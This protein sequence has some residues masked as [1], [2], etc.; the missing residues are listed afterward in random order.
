VFADKQG[1]P[2][3]LSEALRFIRKEMSA[4]VN[5]EEVIRHG[6]FRTRR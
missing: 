4:G 5:A 3:W 1:M 6:G 2:L